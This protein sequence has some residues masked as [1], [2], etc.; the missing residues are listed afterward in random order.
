MKKMLVLEVQKESAF[1]LLK[2]PFTIVN[3]NRRH[4]AYRCMVLLGAV[5]RVESFVRTTTVGI[6][7]AFL[8]S[9]TVV[10]QST[11][12]TSDGKTLVLRVE[13]HLLRRIS[14]CFRI[15]FAGFF[16]IV[17]SYGK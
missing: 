15:L 2:I 5:Y 7:K 4:S 6:S 16:K 1:V 10:V 8:M 3:I 17:V 9:K 12:T 11:F 14:S 13:I